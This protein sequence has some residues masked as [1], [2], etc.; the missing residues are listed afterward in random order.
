[1]G[2][3]HQCTVSNLADVNAARLGGQRDLD[4]VLV[5]QACQGISNGS[6][7][8]VKTKAKVVV[9]V[10]GREVGGRVIAVKGYSAQAGQQAKVGRFGVHLFAVEQMREYQAMLNATLQQQKVANLG[11]VVAA[12][13]NASLPKLINFAFQQ[14][15]H[16]VKCAA[17][18]CVVQTAQAGFNKGRVDL[19][20]SVFRL[21]QLANCQLHMP[22]LV[23]RIHA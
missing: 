2:V 8:T 14:T 16:G 15:Q 9:V 21:K 4:G 20:L 22:F 1:M 10:V 5:M 13:S 19:Y 3:V 11:T 6:Q 17:N 23:V 7:Y 12:F 18:I